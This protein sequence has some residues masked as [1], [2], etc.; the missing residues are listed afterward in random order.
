[1]ED[2]RFRYVLSGSLLGVE[3]NSVES[4]PVGY[5]ETHVLYPL[6]YEEFLQVFNVSDELISVLKDSFINKT[7]IDELIHQRLMDI[8]RLYLIIGGMPAAINAYQ[9]SNDIN[10]VITEHNS[11]IEQYKLDFTQYEETNKKLQLRN[12]YEMIP[13]ELNEMNKRFMV[14]DINKNFRIE[15]VENS[16]LWLTKS[17][18]AL[19]IYNVTEPVIPLLL[20]QKRN[21]FKLFLSDVGLLTTLYGKTIKL[22]IVN[23]ERNINFGSV[24]ENYA[25]QE[26]LAHG[27]K[28]Y[29]YNSKKYGELDFVIEYNDEVLPIEIKSG[30][31]YQKHSAL[32]NVLNIKQYE[33][34]NAFVFTDFNIR[35][36]DKITYYP[37]YTLMFLDKNNVEI[38]LDNLDSIK[39]LSFNN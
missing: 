38:K 29:Y 4:A 14:R 24:F 35:V 22:K 3:L 34:K 8:F 17:G 36:K 25:A 16:F 28:A 20:N 2:R 13:S 30:K 12:I 9:E 5:L 39:K 23:R 27:F 10:D 1:V 37:I 26:L 31:D 6:D 33:I 21:L 18:V 32:N 7:Q 11:I 15:H 19:P